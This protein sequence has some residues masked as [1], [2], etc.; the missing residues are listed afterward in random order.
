LFVGRFAV[1]SVHILFLKQMWL[2]L[3]GVILV[4]IIIIIGEWNSFALL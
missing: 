3:V 2:I 1:H 4:I